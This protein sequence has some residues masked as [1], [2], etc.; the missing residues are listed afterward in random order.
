MLRNTKKQL[1]HPERPALAMAFYSV[2]YC[3]DF[4][5]WGSHVLVLFYIFDRVQQDCLKTVV[6]KMKKLDCERS[7]V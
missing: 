3:S 6:N 2:A 4:S 1:E 7:H 5:G